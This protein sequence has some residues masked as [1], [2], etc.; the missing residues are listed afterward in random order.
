MSAV[1]SDAQV[2][3]Q[4][5]GL[6]GQR[7]TINSL[8]DDSAEG[9]ACNTH[10]ATTK[11]ALLEAHD[12]SWATKRIALAQ[13]TGVEREGW[14]YVYAAPSDMLN[15]HTARLIEQGGRP[16]SNPIPFL[17]ESNTTTSAFIIATDVELA[18]ELIYTKDVPLALWPA[19]AVEAF[20]YA[21]AVK[22]AL[23]LPVKENLARALKGEAVLK[24]R[25]AMAADAM[26]DRRDPPAEAESIRRRGVI[27]RRF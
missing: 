26:A 15:A 14:A 17:I 12:W 7:Q 6:C 2:A 24:L 10:F 25:E 11:Q 22:L 19:S 1:T 20:V 23:T 8:L 4:A 9:L 16:D 3:N 18:P 21:L 13:L 5:L 27:P